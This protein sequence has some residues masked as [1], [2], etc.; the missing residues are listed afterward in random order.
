MTP[1]DLVDVLEHLRFSRQGPS[2]WCL[3]RLDQDVAVYLARLLRAR[4]AGSLGANDFDD[5]G[6]RSLE[7]LRC[8]NLGDKQ[9]ETRTGPTTNVAKATRF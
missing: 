6:L 3:V 1:R 8:V 7:V 4:G 2:R 5:P 9:F